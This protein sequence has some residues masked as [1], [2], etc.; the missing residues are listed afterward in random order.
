MPRCILP[1]IN[2]M[3]HYK[4]STTEKIV[5]I[6]VAIIIATGFFLFYTDLPKFEEYVKEDGIAEWLTVAGPDTGLNCVLLQ[7]Y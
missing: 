6:T 3:N 5:L 2:R 1:N 4:L 7:V